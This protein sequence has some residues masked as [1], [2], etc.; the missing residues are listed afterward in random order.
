MKRMLVSA[1][2]LV[3]LVILAGCVP[4]DPDLSPLA[5]PALAVAA[6]EGD[7]VDVPTLPDFLEMLAGPAGWV[8]LGAVLSA[9]VAR[10]PWYNAQGTVFKRGFILV[11]SAILAICAR[12][13]LT[14]VPVSFWGATAE[15]WYIIAGIVATYLGSQGWFNLKVKPDR[16]KERV[17]KLVE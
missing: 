12:L 16:E 8:I 15:Y 17:W 5:A 9:L 3:V 6:M 4:V 2:V 10:W 13:L 1:A 11:A 7:P 14:Y